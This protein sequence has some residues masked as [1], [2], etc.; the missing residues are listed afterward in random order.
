MYR[1][2]LCSPGLM[3]P[4]QNTKGHWHPGP[5]RHLT[6]PL[7]NPPVT[8]GTLPAPQE[9][10]AW[11]PPQNRGQMTNALEA[12]PPRGFCLM[13]LLLV[14]FSILSDGYKWTL[15]VKLGILEVIPEWVFSSIT[16]RPLRGTFS[17]RKSVK[18]Q[19]NF[20]L[21]SQEQN[22]DVPLWADWLK[23][24]ADKWVRCAFFLND[25]KI[26]LKSLKI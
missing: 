1:T 5:L 20:T 11:P 14:S 21:P 15:R 10:G 26:I 7:C 9:H 13:S 4:Q 2:L 3:I 22:P 17:M 12:I 19:R 25:G 18:Q 23:C 16:I 24:Y 6:Q 8:A